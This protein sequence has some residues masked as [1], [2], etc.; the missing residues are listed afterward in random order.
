MPSAKNSSIRCMIFPFPSLD[1]VTNIFGC[2]Q[3]G[4]CKFR[5]ANFI[6]VFAYPFVHSSIFRWIMGVSWPYLLFVTVH[7][8]PAIAWSLLMNHLFQTFPNRPLITG[9]AVIKSRRTLACDSSTNSRV[10]RGKK[11]MILNLLIYLLG[12]CTGLINLCL[13]SGEFSTFRF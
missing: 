5:R 12:H 8:T 13:C 10:F 6:L 7:W 2:I 3:D 4:I 1:L 9:H 11:H